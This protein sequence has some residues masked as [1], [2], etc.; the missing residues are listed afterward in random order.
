MPAPEERPGPSARDLAWA[1]KTCAEAGGKLTAP[2][3]D[4]LSLLLASDHPLAAYDL[5]EQMQGL[6]GQ[7]HPPTVYRALEF[8]E[9]IGLVHRISSRKAYVVCTRQTHRHR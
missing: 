5:I 4:V 2:R 7:T 6:R 1:E 8:L 9:Q 3:R